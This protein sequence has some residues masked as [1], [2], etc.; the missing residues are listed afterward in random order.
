MDGFKK[1][2]LQNGLR[3]ISVPMPHVESATVMILVGAGSR[4]ELKTNNGIS[5]FLEHMAFKGTVSR[6]S[7]LIISSL[8]EGIGGEFNAFT[9]KDHTA[10]YIKAAKKHLPLLFD[11]LS[12]MLLHSKFDHAEIER[13][14]GVITEEINL[15][16]DTPMRRIGTIFEE[17]LYGDH[18]LGWDIAGKKE[19]IKSLKREDFIKYVGGLYS[20][21]N[22]I[23]SVAGGIGTNGES[24]GLSEKCLGSWKK[25]D[26]WQFKK[27]TANSAKDK[28][29]VVYKKTE[30]AH[31]CLGVPSFDGDHPDHYVLEVLAAILGGGMSSRL[32]IEVRERRG[33]A[34]YVRTDTTDYHET[35]NLVTQAGVDLKRI[36]D[37]IKVILFE[38]QRITKEPVSHSELTKAKEFLK[39]RLILEMEDS[40]NIAALYGTQALLNKRIDTSRDML[41]KI[42]KVTQSDITR[43]A[44]TV[45]KAREMRLAVIGPFKDKQR[46][47]KL[48]K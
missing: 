29:R 6:P 35:G 38:Y 40:R 39:G 18:P 4:Y 12:D 5:H 7:A 2:T 24:L 44:K 43:V 37:A 10:Y 34:Y 11:I 30:Q 1:H 13:E 21:N 32:F 17:L 26:V 25:R 23:I 27:V 22:T 41:D 33:L 31:L 46:F 16:E 20:P 28:L 36:D 45:L 42:S 14:K 48:L 9:S 47:A 19:V 3:L 15:Y 8:I